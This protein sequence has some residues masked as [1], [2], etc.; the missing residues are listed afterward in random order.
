MRSISCV[1]AFIVAAVGTT[2]LVAQQTLIQ[3]QG[4]VIYYSGSSLDL[5]GGDLAPGMPAGERFGGGGQDPAIIDENGNVL[6][7]AQMVSNAGTC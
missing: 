5:T 1:F 2:S 6:F 4:Q 7:R 3:S